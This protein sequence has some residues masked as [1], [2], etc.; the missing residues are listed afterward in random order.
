MQQTS[1]FYK[2]LLADPAH[3]KETRVQIGE[4]W[5][6]EGSIVTLSTSEP[7]FSGDTVSFGGAVAREIALSGFFPD[8]IPRRAKIT[9]QVRL[10]LGNQVSEWLPK[11]VF[12]IDTRSRDQVTGVTTIHGFDAILMG[13]QE[14]I[15]ADSDVFP[16]SMEDAVK[17]TAAAL[18]LEID[19]RTTFKTGKTYM[20]DHPAAEPEVDEE[21][22]E[23]DVRT[24]SGVTIRQLWR[25]VA[26]AMGGNFITNDLGQLRLIPLNALPASTAYLVN[27]DGDSIT[28]GG[29][30]LLMGT[31]SAAG[32]AVSGDKVF[33]GQ[34]ATSAEVFPALQSISRIIL[35]VDNNSAYV[36]G[37]DTGMTMEVSCPYGSQQMAKDLL[38]Q[39]KD[40]AYQPMAAEDALIDLAAE[41]GDGVTVN[42]VYT[43]LAQKD[44]TFDLF[45]AADIAAPGK[46][47]L[48]SEFRFTSQ[49]QAEYNYE[50]AKTRSLI[51]KTA[52]EIRLEVF[53]EDGAFTTLSQTV[54]GIALEVHGADG[55]GGLTGS[56]S[57]LTQKVDSIEL[58]VSSAD[59]ST[60]F[61]L[62]ADGAELSAKTLKLSVDAANITG[63]LTAGQ[64]ETKDLTVDVANITGKITF[65]N[66]DEEL[67]SDI[68]NAGGISEGQAK[69]LINET[70]V[71]SPTIMGGKF[72]DID[73]VAVLDLSVEHNDV[74]V[75]GLTFSTV[76]VSSDGDETL[77]KNIF[78]IWPITEDASSVG[79]ALAGCS[80]I[81]VS[82]DED[83]EYLGH[84]GLHGD[85]YF[86]DA[87]IDF[88]GASAE[89]LGISVD[90][91][92]IG[93]STA[94]LSVMKYGPFNSYCVVANRSIVPYVDDWEDSDTNIDYL[95][96]ASVP[97]AGLYADS[98]SCC[99][100]DENK[101]NSIEELPEKYLA[102]F[103]HL[104]PKRFKM[105]DGT[106]G[107]YHTGFIAQDVKAAMEAAGVDSTE[108][109]A[110]IKD[111][112][113]DG[114]DIYMLRY[115]EFGAIYA[116]K[117]KQLEARVAKLEGGKTA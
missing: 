68:E 47:E 1:D 111:T 86:G 97:W 38:S 33:V 44:T 84:F 36:S 42:G 6:G 65:E 101:K 21:T 34:R 116:A 73:R 113:K 67:Q 22:G 31:P 15:P 53:G 2:T 41:L 105:N 71:S 12:Y 32:S 45:C 28:F 14:W 63:K 52:E 78:Y 110:W 115:E 40:Y 93:K 3:I 60:T 75:P 7:L 81:S 9:V 100:S 58:S 18:K 77:D 25:W 98:C 56:M 89:D 11:G 108:L 55:K 37:S 72:Y 8:S 13:E 114:N 83:N 59:G 51:S 106:S 109:G 76:K 91:S 103:D 66:L 29:N 62:T 95:G 16:M 5:Y 79:F 24:Q 112:D 74:S 46:P 4:T 43:I 64:I 85:W 39:L 49:Q 117:I 90:L 99:T 17:K 94:W 102:M 61:T 27:E 57:S 70:L 82:V 80:C 92:E 88:G 19:P 54:D 69:T 10:V 35:K 50:L 96:L 26:A 48:E 107:R 30:R 104:T 23:T 20:V 87:T